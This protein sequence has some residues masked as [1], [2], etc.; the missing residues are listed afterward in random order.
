[1]FH[2]WARR[3][4]SCFTRLLH[5]RPW[6]AA[7]HRGLCSGYVLHTGCAYTPNSHGGGADLKNPCLQFVGGSTALSCIPLIRQLRAENKGA[8]FAYSV[9]VD[10]DGATD[11][12]HSPREM[13]HKR[14]VQEMIRSIDA[15]AD[16][17]DSQSHA[18]ESSGRR[19]W[20]AVKLVRS[21]FL[22]LEATYS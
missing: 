6:S 9:E 12:A 21:L 13:G 8:L 7:T 15:A 16:F 3:R 19:T 17:E 20:V 2:P 22:I 1:M 18:D 10:A 11:G 14:I 5:L 4:L